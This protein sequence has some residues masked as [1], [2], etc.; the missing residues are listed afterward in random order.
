MLLWTWVYKCLCEILLLILVVCFLK[1]KDTSVWHW[2]LIGH[3]SK[4]EAEYLISKLFGFHIVVRK[5][6]N[7]PPSLKAGASL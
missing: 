6:Q 2:I 4:E 1:E 5:N 3:K 7:I